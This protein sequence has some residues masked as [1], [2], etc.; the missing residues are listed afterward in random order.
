MTIA[1]TLLP[2]L[3][4]REAHG[5]ERQSWTQ[6]VAGTDWALTLTTD[7]VD[8][9]GCLL[10]EAEL[11][12]LQAAPISIADLKQ[13]ASVVADRV[14]GLM[15]TLRLIEVDE[16]RNEALLRSDGPTKRT[17][18]LAYYEILMTAGRRVL[19]R[20]FQRSSEK[21][22]REQIAFA[23][24]HETVAQLADDLCR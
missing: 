21:G 10:W 7:R 1:E 12:R 22:Q 13:H 15:E 18:S 16:T 17:G 4:E 14:R 2:K 5:G 9:L 6:A 20:R 19:V 11:T 23:I 24:T 8:T 3:S